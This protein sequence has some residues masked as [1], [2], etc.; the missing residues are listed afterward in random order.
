MKTLKL[1]NSDEVCLVDD[2]IWLRFCRY[3]WRLKKS[4]A[5][6]YVVRSTSKYTW[7]SGKRK[8]KTITIRLHRIVMNCPEDKEVHH[9]NG[10]VLDNRRES[11]EIVEPRDHKSESGRK[12][13]NQ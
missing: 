12:R 6:S 10:N 8:R 2:D 7:E 4:G 1:S 11:L 9:K 3:K 13:W 5:C